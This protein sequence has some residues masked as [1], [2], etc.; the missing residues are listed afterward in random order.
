M[1]PW[2]ES[3]KDVTDFGLHANGSFAGVYVRVNTA[4]TD[5]T[6]FTSVLKDYIIKIKLLYSACTIKTP[7]R[8]IGCEIQSYQIVKT[9]P[10]PANK[11]ES[12]GL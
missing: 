11:C 4:Q 5:F 9:S 3:T 1:P 2:N 10:G 8:C 12:G 6:F 7:S